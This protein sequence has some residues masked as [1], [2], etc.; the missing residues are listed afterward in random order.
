M[1]TAR[2][3]NILKRIS[4]W[5]LSVIVTGWSVKRRLKNPA[6]GHD[7]Q[8]QKHG[9]CIE[10][11]NL[12]GQKR[13][14]DAALWSRSG[15]R[16]R[17]AAGLWPEGRIYPEKETYFPLGKDST[18]GPPFPWKK[19]RSIL[20]GTL[21]VWSASAGKW[22]RNWTKYPV[23][24]SGEGISATSRYPGIGTAVRAYR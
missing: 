4:S 5:P 16:A 15:D 2:P 10:T 8:V 1:G 9:L 14:D 12:W 3:W 18:S 13:A 24:I 21:P 23:N 17:T 22:P 19:W 11:G 20:K 6:A 7:R